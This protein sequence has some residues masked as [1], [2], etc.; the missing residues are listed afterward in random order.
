MLCLKGG[1]WT[2]FICFILRFNN[3]IL[4]GRFSYRSNSYCFCHV[5]LGI[6]LI[7]LYFK[8]NII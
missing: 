3:R 7:S 5:L 6:K 1:V 8:L 2:V 4:N